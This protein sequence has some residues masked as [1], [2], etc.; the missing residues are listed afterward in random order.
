[1]LARLS[2]TLCARKTGPLHHCN[3][4]LKEIMK[5]STIQSENVNKGH[6][7]TTIATNV[8]NGIR[9]HEH[10]PGDVSICQSLHQ[11]SAVCQTRLHSDAAAVGVSKV[12]KVV[13]SGMSILLLQILSQIC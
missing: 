11:L 1:V 13:Q 10:K 3:K 5:C 9:F 4:I 6:V 2:C 8:Q 7:A 12:S